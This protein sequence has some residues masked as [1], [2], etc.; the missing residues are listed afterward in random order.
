LITLHRIIEP[1]IETL[2]GIRSK[3]ANKPPHG[4]EGG[5]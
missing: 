4:V 3:I 2:T 1:S 5:P